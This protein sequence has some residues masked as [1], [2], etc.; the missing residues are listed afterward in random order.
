MGLMTAQSYGRNVL[1]AGQLSN[2]TSSFSMPFSGVA[3]VQPDNKTVDL[4][5]SACVENEPISRPN[6]YEYITLREIANQLGVSQ[7][8]LPVNGAYT[9]VIPYKAPSTGNSSITQET[10]GRCGL[11]FGLLNN[12]GVTG[13]F[14][15]NYAGD[16]SANGLWALDYS[17]LMHYGEYYHFFLIGVT[18]IS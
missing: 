12:I 10:M 4:I 16:L 1:I 13:A 18:M 2:L 17:P 15:R 9:M 8:Q 6:T 3:K 14:G 11:R 5:F 7:F